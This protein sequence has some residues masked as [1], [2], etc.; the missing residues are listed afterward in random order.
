MA[1]SRPLLPR[2]GLGLI[3]PACAALRLQRKY[4]IADSY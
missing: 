2:A 3:R 1:P 4:Q